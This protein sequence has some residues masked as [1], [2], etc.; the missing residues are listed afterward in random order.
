MSTADHMSLSKRI[1]IQWSD[2]EPV[3]NTDTLVLTSPGRHYVDIRLVKGSAQDIEWAFCGRTTSNGATTTYTHE[4]DSS[5]QSIDDSGHFEQMPTD[6][7]KETGSMVNPES[8]VIEG[9]CEIWRRMDP[10]HAKLMPRGNKDL[11]N[12]TYQVLEKWKGDTLVGKIV[13][14]GSWIQG[15]RK[16]P[17]INYLRGYY[18]IP[19]TEATFVA[20][21]GT[22]N[23]QLLSNKIY[24]LQ[25]P[26][27]EGWTVQES[28]AK[29]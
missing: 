13:R 28:S 20:S 25:T 19:G 17:D 9:Y 10:R 7:I 1:S 2:N 16:D 11:S 22:F 29:K 6:D 14:V 24:P 27:A 26:L 8:G 5:G 15:I 21:R 3:E 23:P 4:I 18:A 12:I